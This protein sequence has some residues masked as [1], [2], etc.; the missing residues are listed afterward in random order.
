MS[1]L[2]AQ[3]VKEKQKRQLIETKM[4]VLLNELDD[5]KRTMHE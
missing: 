1:N 5:I 4:H 3:L 2:Q